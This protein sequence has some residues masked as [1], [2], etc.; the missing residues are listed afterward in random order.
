MKRRLHSFWRLPWARKV[1]LVQSG[2]LLLLAKLLVQFVPFRWLA[3]RLGRLNAANDKEPSQQQMHEIRQIQWAIRLWGKRLPWFTTCL[4]EA[5]T[6]KF[7]LSRRQI[8]TS[9]FLGA[10]FNAERSLDAHAWLRCGS[11]YVTGGAG[12]KAYGVLASFS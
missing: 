12:E 8:E 10:A 7:L 4:T 9:L 2:L 1:L 5:M 3:P 6:A 11:V